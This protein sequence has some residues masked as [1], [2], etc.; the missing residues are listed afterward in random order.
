VRASSKKARSGAELGGS[1]DTW[2]TLHAG[3]RALKIEVD[4]HF[5]TRA[6]AYLDE[7]G[8]WNRVARLTGYTTGSSQVRFVLLDS[9]LFLG[10]LRGIDGPFLDIGSGG[11]LPGLVLKLARPA[12]SVTLVEA[13]RR[14]A[15][16]LRHAVRQLELEGVEVE[17]A[18]AETLIGQAGWAGRF[19]GVTMRAVAAPEA[20]AALAQPFLRREGR[21]VVALGPGQRPAVGTVEHLR[22]R[23]KAAGLRIDRTFLII[24]PSLAGRGGQLDV[25]RE[26]RGVRG[27]RPDRGEPEGRGRK[28]DHRR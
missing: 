16:F 5:E 14:R 1:A 10:V 21:A 28:D 20:A 23:D 18:R 24:A 12:W 2:A 15:N 6:R 7:L 9:L 27:P 19:A 22:I 4:S 17:E 13:N 25:P 8:R 3:I 26:T 11:G